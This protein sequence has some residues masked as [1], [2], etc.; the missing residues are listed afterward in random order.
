MVN[1]QNPK[2]QEKK[3]LPSY[4]IIRSC[5]ISYNWLLFFLGGG[6]TVLHCILSYE[7]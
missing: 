2:I 6:H 7:T 1:M 5:H 3:N 4:F